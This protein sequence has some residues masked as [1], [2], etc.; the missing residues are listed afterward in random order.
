MESQILQNFLC[1]YIFKN[2]KLTNSTSKI[3]RAIYYNN[4][5]AWL[6]H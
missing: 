2:D 3:H 1:S 5:Q 4:I 6:A